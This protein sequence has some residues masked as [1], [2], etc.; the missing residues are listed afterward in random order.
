MSDGIPSLD[1]NLLPVASLLFFPLSAS[2]RLSDRIWRS[3]LCQDGN[4]L[5]SFTAASMTRAIE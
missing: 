4:F 2:K 3:C 1:S 5:V